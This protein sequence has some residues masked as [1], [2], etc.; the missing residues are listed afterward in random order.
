MLNLI[1][2]DGALS[3]RSGR[4]GF[5]RPPSLAPCLSLHE[6]PFSGFLVFHSG[7]GLFALSLSEADSAREEGREPPA[8]L[9][10]ME[11]LPPMRG[12]FF[13][14]QGCLYYKC[15]GAYIRVRSGSGGGPPTASAVEPYVPVTYINMDPITAAGDAYQPENRLSAEKCLRYTALEG[16]R[17]YRLPVP[18]GEVTRVT[19]EGRLLI[20]G[21]DN[22]YEEGVL[23]FTNA[24][25]VSFPPADNTVSV[26]YSLP[27]EAAFNAL[28]SCSAAISC[29]AGGLPCVVMGRSGGEP[30]AFFFS[31]SHIAMDPGY[32]PMEQYQLAGDSGEAV[33][34][35]AMQRGCL[36]IFKERSIYRCTPGSS[37]VDGRLFVDMPC[38]SL[39]SRIGCSYPRSLRLVENNLL[40]CSERG[41]HR[42]TDASAS[43]E[44]T[45]QS[46]SDK[47][48]GSPTRPGLL[49]ELAAVSKDS[50][51]ALDD[52]RRYLL[53]VGERAWLWDYSVSTPQNPSWF[54]FDNYALEGF[55][56]GEGRIWL[57]DGDGAIS[58]LE[59]V[60]ADYGEPIRKLYRF[61]AIAP[62]GYERLR[63]ICDVIISCRAD[64]NSLTDL[65]YI[66]DYERRYDESPLR[67][68]SWSLFPR[69]LALRSLRG[70]G[71]SQL[72]RRRPMCRR[73]KHFSMLLENGRAGEDLSIAH[74]QLSYRLCGK[75]R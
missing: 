26:T 62:G 27:D 64:T 50:V 36:I 70:R 59:R 31:G 40:W 23:T 12:S 49:A 14:Y 22:S 20:P 30:N 32:F 8:P 47:I 18:A 66:S 28:M 52:G 58:R 73:V 21:E 71:I 37:T 2:S 42:L 17:E 65:C 16:Q 35:F 24:P 51:C 46:L 63:D 54:L 67:C 75:L 25:P 44:Q 60:F 56:S 41:L 10:L 55:A 38:E 74:A 4:V 34:A 7:S 1:W 33:T 61:A 45:V 69:N 19:V 72:F 57:L 13:E 3:S 9:L 48:N 43:Y 29:A 15:P 53:S 5:S 68:Y 39:N 11:G 6:R